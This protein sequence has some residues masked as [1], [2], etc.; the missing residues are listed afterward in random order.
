MNMDLRLAYIG[1]EISGLGFRLAGARTYTPPATSGEVRDAI[2]EARADCDL[3]L[4]ESGLSELV[5]EDLTAMLI[6]QPVPP[7]LVI[8]AIL[9]EQEL[10]T[11]A[12][13]EAR[14]VLGIG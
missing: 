11:S 3:V 12:L 8:P 13:T 4:L 6:E 14:R 9:S 7:V 2:R 10:T 5:R 1:E